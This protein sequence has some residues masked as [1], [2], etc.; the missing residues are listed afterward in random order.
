MIQCW[1][2][3]Y[4]IAVADSCTVVAVAANSCTGVAVAANRC[5]IILPNDSM[6][7]GSWPTHT[8]LAP[9]FYRHQSFSKENTHTVYSV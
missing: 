9:K 8:T 4:S 6:L 3:L 7:A 2:L 1:L 5:R